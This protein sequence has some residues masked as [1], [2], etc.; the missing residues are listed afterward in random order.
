MG[1]KA[2]STAVL[3]GE[4]AADVSVRQV[5]SGVVAARVALATG[6]PEDPRP[7]L[8]ASLRRM[9]QLDV[10][11]EPFWSLCDGRPGLAHV[12]PRSAG[13]LMQSPT[14]FEDLMKILFTTNC[15]WALT[16]SMA[17]NLVE[18]LGVPAPSGRKAFPG[19]AACARQPESFW[20][21]VVKAGYRAPHCRAIS[22]AF[23]SG[24]LSEAHFADPELATEEVRRRVLA[25][26]G[27]GAYAAGHVL[28]GLGRC[29][30]L[31][32]DSW[33]RARMAAMLGRKKAPKDAWFERRYKPF[34]TYAGLA[35]WCELTGEG[36]EGAL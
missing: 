30:D 21:E 14:L 16:R 11:L 28:R 1:G 12:R 35:L 2:L 7:A 13:Y 10:D 23:A 15:S 32:L 31:A 24:E 34:G 6:A 8:R 19:A 18:A 29:D 3:V 27:F 25:L 20:R 22:G 9:L 17:R 4:R 26:P 36:L 33:C 5:G